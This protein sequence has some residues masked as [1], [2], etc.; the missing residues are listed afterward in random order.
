MKLRLLLTF[1]VLLA[2]TGCT[3]LLLRQTCLGLSTNVNYCLAPLPVQAR[4]L[5]E[6]PNAPKP[7]RAPKAPAATPAPTTKSQSQ[8]QSQTQKVS[9]EINGKR[10]ELLSQLELDG[11]RLSVVGL[12]PMGQPLFDVSFD[13]NQLISEQSVLLGDNFR[14]EYLIALLQLIYWP[15][16]ALNA[17]LSGGLVSEQ[18]CPQRRCR[19]LTSPEDGGIVHISYSHQEPWLATVILEMPSAGMKLKITP[20]A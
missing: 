13:G 7:Q 12:A 16:P 3:Q 14:A 2:A 10:H 5:R 6:K 4:E 9:I 17:A 19:V 11:H 1:L 20:L 8:S 15:E 18:A